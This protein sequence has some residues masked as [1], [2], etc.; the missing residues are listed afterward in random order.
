M[1]IVRGTGRVAIVGRHWT[2]K[3]PWPVARPHGW[4]QAAAW[5]ALANVSEW[6]HSDKPGVNPVRWA[7]LGGLVNVYRTA[8]CLEADP[9]EWPHTHPHVAADRAHSNVGRVA[10]RLVWIDYD[11]SGEDHIRRKGCPHT[12][13]EA[14]A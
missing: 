1:R 14:P 10:G 13:Q 7:L 11:S 6:E 12:R 3:V 2:I 8:Q 5:G 4:L 9:D